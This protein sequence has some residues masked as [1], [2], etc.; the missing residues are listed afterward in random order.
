MNERQRFVAT[1]RYQTRDRAPICDFSFW[2]ETLERWHKEGLPRSVD[3]YSSDDY[4]GM[5]S[6]MSYVLSPE[7]SALT[8]PANPKRTVLSGVCVGLMPEFV[9][10]V[11]EDRGDAD[12]IQQSD[13]VRVLRSKSLKLDPVSRGAP[14][15][16]PGQLEEALP[17]ST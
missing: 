2:D 13:G 10:M 11:L 9:P 1:M 6:L 7:S 12:V 3:R 14:P 17:T 15:D 8:S 5:D 4:F 16:R